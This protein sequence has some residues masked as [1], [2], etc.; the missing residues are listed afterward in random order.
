MH[1]AGAALAAANPVLAQWIDIGDSWEQ[2]DPGPIPGYDLRLLKLTSPLVATHKPAL[3]ITST[4]HAREYA[5]EIGTLL[6]E[7]LV[8]RYGTDPDVT[9]I[10]DHHEVHVLLVM[11]PDGRKQAEAG[12]LWRKNTDNDD[13]CGNPSLWGVDLNR[14]YDFE[15]EF[16]GA[17]CS[18]TFS[19]PEADSE[20]EVDASQDYMVGL[21]PDQ[22]PDDLETEAPL[23]AEGIFIDLHSFGE[24]M[25][26]PWSFLPD[27]GNPPNEQGLRTLS[28]KLAYFPGYGSELGSTGI[29][30]GTSKDFASDG[31]LTRDGWHLD[32]LRLEAASDGM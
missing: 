2:V 9:W 17:P 31:D 11:N 32:D 6:A 7:H 8:A 3:F 24:V 1:A 14:N 13:G 29:L 28:R 18:E 30:H 20:P 10:L 21:F 19:G 15:W 26:G 23:T 5:T 27:G 25:F 16:S 22:R 12:L 4:I